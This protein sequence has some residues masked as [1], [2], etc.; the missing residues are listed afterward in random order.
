VRFLAG[1][2][3]SFMPD[4]QEVLERAEREFKKGNYGGSSEDLR[5]ATV[6]LDGVTRA[7]GPKK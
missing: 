5:I 3:L 1:S 7:P 6:L 2:G 4:I